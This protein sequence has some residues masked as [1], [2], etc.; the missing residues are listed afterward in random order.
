MKRWPL[1]ALAGLVLASCA[2]TAPGA[3]NCA[4]APCLRKPDVHYEPTP[5]RVVRQML[6]LAKVGPDDIVYD[7]GSGD[8][9]I[10]IAAASKYGA[11]A[12]G[13]DI[14]PKRVAEARENAEEAGVA[15]KVTF[16]N[17][18]VLRADFSEAT[19]V[20]L[21]L[22]RDLNARLKPVLLEQLKPGTRVISYYHDMPDWEP[23]ETVRTSRA[24]IYRWTIPRQR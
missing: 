22:S 14:D 1:L 12:V 9:R 3:S 20:T 15:G 10:P 7:L 18:D 6:Q 16:R 8:G 5:D 21:F 4:E 13:I 24:K 19:V 2:P 17:E 23:E 11:R